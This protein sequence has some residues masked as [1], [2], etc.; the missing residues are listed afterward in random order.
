MKSSAILYLGATLGLG[1]TA[2]QIQADAVTD[3][4]T[5]LLRAARTE[6]INPPK[7]SRA[8]AIVHVSIY[9]AVNGIT[10]THRPYLSLSAAPE[11]ASIEAAVHAAAFTAAMAQFTNTDVKTTNFTALY[12]SS[13]AALPQNASTTAG[14]AWGQQVA[15][16][17]LA[18]RAG[19]NSASVVVYT[20]LPAPG[21]WRPTLPA[22]AAA[23]LPAWGT[24]KCFAIPDGTR[25][26]PYAPPS[27]TSSAYAFEVNITKEIGSS[28]STTRTADQTQIAQFW[29]DGGG[30]ETPPGHWNH[31]AQ[32]V[33]I[34]QGNTLEENAR[35]FAL[36]NI[37]MADAA[38]SCWDAKYTFNLWRPITAIREADT[39]NN[40]ETTADP[41]WTPLIAT[42][43]FPECTSGHSTFSRAASTILAS[44][45]GTDEIAFS[46][47]SD[48]LP[49]VTRNYQRF[50]QASDES[51][52]S[53][54]FGG[55]HFPTANIAGQAAGFN[56]ANLVTQYFLQPSSATSFSAIS[57]VNGNSQLTLQGEANVTYEIQ[58]SSDLVVWE[59]IATLSSGTGVIQFTDA[60]AVGNTLRFY[61]ASIK[62]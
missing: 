60:N 28:T 47:V 22:N 31:I 56:I 38:I 58:A 2:N 1:L 50:S 45:Y 24:V 37:A 4:N 30:T 53:R 11:G 44:F 3:W 9:D 55:I 20:N 15:E 25:F 32:D 21:I 10:K 49:G 16:A 17:M 43:P 14:L 34:A 51:G 46:S 8:A 59:T 62:N 42:P 13:V 40:P 36:L 23:L 33:A 35:L 57:R 48:G 6:R 52:V 41:A 29:A 54:I 19:D 5:A 26:R 7:F 61:K 18:S 12:N 39:D 27:L